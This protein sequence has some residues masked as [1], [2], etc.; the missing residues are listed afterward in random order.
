MYSQST[1]SSSVVHSNLTALLDIYE[2][3]GQR[4]IP[5]LI[6]SSESNA[7]LSTIQILMSRPTF[8]NKNSWT[9]YLRELLPF[10]PL[11]MGRGACWPG[12]SLDNYFQWMTEGGTALHSVDE[13]HCETV[14]LPLFSPHHPL[15]ISFLSI[16]VAV[17]LSFSPSHNLML[18]SSLWEEGV[19]LFRESCWHSAPAHLLTRSYNND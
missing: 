7:R 17:S 16:T 3:N 9:M 18:L 10:K 13:R 2:I 6:W 1:C 4:R 14:C 5:G 19:C 15:P 11:R 8:L 12:I